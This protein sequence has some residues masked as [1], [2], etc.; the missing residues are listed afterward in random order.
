MIDKD[1]AI[2]TAQKYAID[3]LLVRNCKI[4]DLQATVID[5]YFTIKVEPI[6]VTQDTIVYT[7]KSN[8]VTVDKRTGDT[9]LIDEDGYKPM[10]SK[11]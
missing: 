11:L 5:D 9:Y 6:E 10:V 1:K 3:H 7:N 2:E 8:L 4:E